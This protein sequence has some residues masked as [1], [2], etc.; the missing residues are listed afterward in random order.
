MSALRFGPDHP[1]ETYVAHTFA[2][3]TVGTGEAVINY[4]VAGALY[5]HHFRRV[6]D[7]D[8]H[9]MGAASD[10]QARR[11]C[12]LVKLAGQTIDYRSFPTMPHSMHGEAP[13]QFA[14]LLIEF[15]AKLQA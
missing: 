2:E 9:L 11:V 7:N 1:A 4:A 13:K 3:K 12:E 14:E 8:G 10:V 5:T 6:A 15:A